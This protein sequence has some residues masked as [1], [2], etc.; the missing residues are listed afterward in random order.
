MENCIARLKRKARPE[1]EFRCLHLKTYLESDTHTIILFFI[2]KKSY[3]KQQ[4]TTQQEKIIATKAKWSITWWLRNKTVAC[5]TVQRDCIRGRRREEKNKENND[6]VEERSKLRK[7]EN[8]A[9]TVN[10]QQFLT[11]RSQTLVE[12]VNMRR[13]KFKK[14]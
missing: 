14:N 3:Y 5:R 7:I 12:K 10:I 13:R 1:D 6:W 2:T 4:W 11:K 9:V 8:T